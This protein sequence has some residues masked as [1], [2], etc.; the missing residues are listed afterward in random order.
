MSAPAPDNPQM[1]SETWIR[2]LLPAAKR[3]LTQT[4]LWT[5]AAG[6]LTITQAWLLAHLCNQI[7]F[8]Q[9]AQETLTPLLAWAFCVA[10]LRGFCS[11]RLEASATAGAA[12]IKQQLHDQL[13]G[14][15]TQGRPAGIL[16]DSARVMEALTT[17][18]DQLEP[19]IAKFIPSLF[20]AAI[21]PLLV[22]VV[23]V[24]AEWRASL[25]LLFS[26]PFIPLLMVLI[27]KGTERFNQK[28]WERLSRLSQFLLDRVRGLPD[29]RRFGIWKTEALRLTTA[30]EAYHQGT[31]AVLRLAFLSALTLEFFA[32]VGT[33]VVAVIIGFQLLAATLTLERGLLVLLL[34]P[35]FYLPLRMLGQSYHNRMHGIAAADT[36]MPLAEIKTPSWGETP[37]PNSPLTMQCC[38]VSFQYSRTGRGVHD[39]NLDIPAGSIIALVG[40]SG[41]GKS[42]IARLLLGLTA[43]TS[44]TVL[45]NGVDIRQ[46]RQNEWFA[47]LGW[48]PQRPFFKQGTIRENLLLGSSVA[49]DH[50][51]WQALTYANL[52][53]VVQSSRDGLDTM[54]GSIGG[55]LS[56]GE[57]KRLALARM[58]VKNSRF[59]V[60]DEPTAGL[61]TQSAQA[62]MET[63]RSLAPQHTILIISHHP[64]TIRYTD[65]VLELLD[66]QLT[67]CR[68]STAYLEQSYA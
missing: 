41:S 17:G 16:P 47:L 31:M 51:L 52:K 14:N 48:V 66:G 26:A 22:L 56:G 7:V 25:V 9:T 35:E 40:P 10:L 29:I 11:Y 38:N 2:T 20:S 27:G 30:S 1:T 33:A 68:P 61:D 42:T 23:V 36:L 60:L 58:L 37:P 59:I 15:V 8:S 28:Q 54:I 50:Q 45:C 4:V 12:T 57:L 55:G 43:P 46:Y 24:P 39:I 3:H 63:I 18:I 49:D 19:Y 44:G 32:T 64:E 62:I 65:T 53:D 34:A 21:L 67:G 6:L 13:L 5:L